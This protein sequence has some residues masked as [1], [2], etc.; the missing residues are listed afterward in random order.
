MAGSRRA[1]RTSSEKL[2]EIAA[3]AV[4]E[5]DVAH[6]H[7]D[8]RRLD[9]GHGG[10]HG[11]RG[12]HVEAAPRKEDLQE[13]GGLGMIVDDQDAG[14]PRLGDTYRLVE[15][16]PSIGASGSDSSTV[17]QSRHNVAEMLSPDAMKRTMGTPTSSSSPSASTLPAP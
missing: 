12:R 5:V 15:H 6:E 1:S 3:V 4:R 14:L 9:R 2:E 16:R 13:L 8:R 7:V 17:T 10:G 11:A